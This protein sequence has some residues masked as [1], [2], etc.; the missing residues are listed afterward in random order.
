[1]HHQRLAQIDQ[2]IASRRSRIAVL[3]A[4]ISQHAADTETVTN[5][6]V[7]FA[8][9]DSLQAML[10]EEVAD[11]KDLAEERVVYAFFTSAPANAETVLT[12]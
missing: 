3:S 8:S 12:K 2:Q 7:W 4:A 6:A 11:L 9:L 5:W 1:M 10:R